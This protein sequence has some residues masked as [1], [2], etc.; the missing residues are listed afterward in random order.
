MGQSYDFVHNSS[1][2]VYEDYL[3]EEYPQ[4]TQMGV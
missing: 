1:L 3:L 4:I 2:A